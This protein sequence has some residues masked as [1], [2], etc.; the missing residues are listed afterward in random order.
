MKPR[1][2]K[3]PN[4]ALLKEALAVIDGIPDVN[5]TLAHQD[6]Y[7]ELDA[8][9]TLTACVPS[10]LIRHPLFQHSRFQL[11]TSDFDGWHYVARRKDLDEGILEVWAGVEYA[12]AVFNLSRDDAWT[13]F[14]DRVHRGRY[15]AC[16]PRAATA[17]ELWQH[18]VRAYLAERVTQL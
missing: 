16:A 1:K 17:K 11:A 8:S 4:L 18:R 15:D 14:G 7:G 6:N 9:T 10:W 3:V 13:L 5:V 12:A 2:P